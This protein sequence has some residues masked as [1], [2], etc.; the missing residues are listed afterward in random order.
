ME[1][2]CSVSN[3]IASGLDTFDY[4]EISIASFNHYGGFDPITTAFEVMEKNG[5]RDF[6]LYVYA[7]P[8]LIFQDGQSHHTKSDASN[9]TKSV[10]ENKKSQRFRQLFKRRR[11]DSNLR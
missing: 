1:Q 3:C 4:Q 11:Q 10:S 5:S 7:V 8:E 2:L 6:D 9:L